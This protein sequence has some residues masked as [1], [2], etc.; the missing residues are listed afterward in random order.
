MFPT[1]SSSTIQQGFFEK[2]RS[3]PPCD[4]LQMCCLSRRT[5]EMRFEGEGQTG[6]IYLEKGEVIHAQ[7]EGTVGEPAAAEILS[8]PPGTFTFRDAAAAPQRTLKAT[9]D[10]MLQAS[11]QHQR[12]SLAGD[13]PPPPGFDS[14]GQEEAGAVVPGPRIDT[15]TQVPRLLIY[16]E[17]IEGRTYDINLPA[18]HLGR[19]PTNEIILREPSISGRHCV[20]LLSEGRVT[21]RDLNSSNGTF[22]NGQQVTEALLE[23]NDIIRA[24]TALIK[25][26]VAL[27]RPRLRAESSPIPPR[28]SGQMQQPAALPAVT[29]LL[30]LPTPAHDGHMAHD[31]GPSMS[32][33]ISYARIAES[34]KRHSYFG[35]R[36]P[37]WLIA[38]LA[39][40]ILI[41]LYLIIGSQEW[42][43]TWLRLW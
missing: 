23:V 5:G 37:P 31:S 26:E 38:L 33:P 39:L 3:F 21:V 30:P 18:I 11:H 16:G 24:G 34:R 9:W 2:I 28:P 15:N 32:G 41:I 20:F 7:L 36:T 17:N 42:A 8:W 29:R 1:E 10:Q 19:A 14:V 22:V 6:F 12:T 35:P 27:K 43:P 13:V 4:I 40:T 25:F